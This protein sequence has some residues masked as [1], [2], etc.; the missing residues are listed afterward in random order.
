MPPLVQTDLF[1]AGGQHAFAG[2]ADRRKIPGHE[3]NSAAH[4]ACEA[5]RDRPSSRPRCAAEE[6][7][8]TVL[9]AAK[10]VETS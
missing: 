10:E 3:A 1:P 2:F 6:D 7:V 8:P 4:R 9:F 5:R